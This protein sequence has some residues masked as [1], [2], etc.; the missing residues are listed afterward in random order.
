ML[1]LCIKDIGALR[2]LHLLADDAVPVRVAA[3]KMI[4]SLAQFPD[5]KKLM[6]YGNHLI[7]KVPV[8]TAIA[9]MVT[10]K[11][12]YVSLTCRVYIWL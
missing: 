3:C 9:V 1:S 11:P 5:V 10:L 12:F 2:M 4:A 8:M 7:S 6:L